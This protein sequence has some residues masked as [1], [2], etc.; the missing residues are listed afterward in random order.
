M[1]GLIAH[2]CRTRPHPLPHTQQALKGLLKDLFSLQAHEAARDGST[3]AEY[4]K[5]RSVTN[6][7]YRSLDDISHCCVHL[8]YLA[9]LFCYSELSHANTPEERT[10]TLQLIR[11]E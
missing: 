4:V 6:D 7:G 5:L 2:A 1:M 8:I 11:Y 10:R 3:V 9:R